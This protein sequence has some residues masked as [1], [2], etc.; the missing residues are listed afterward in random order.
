MIKILDTTLREGE[1]TP[2]VY[3]DI[4]IKIAIAKLLDKIGIDYIEVGHPIVSDSIYRA[5]RSISK[6]KCKDSIIAA[7]SRSV[8]DDID[9][10]L[11]C[12][13]DMIGIFYSIT[14]ERLENVFKV[15]IKEAT[16][17]ICKVITYAKSIKKDVLIRYTPEDTVRSDFNNVGFA[18]VEAIKNGADI[19]SI[20]DTTGFMIPGSN[21]SFYD[22]ISR[23][24]DHFLKQSVNPLI[25]IHCHNDRGL[26]LANAAD[27]IRAGIDIIDASV[28]G[29]GE[30]AGIVDLAQI[31][32]LLSLDLKKSKKY[33]TE[34]LPE[35]Y[36]LVSDYS[37]LKIPIN[38]PIIGENAFTH[39][40]GVH[41]HAAAIDPIH[42][43][44]ISP[45]HFNRKM[46]VSLDQM[47]GLSSVRYALEQLE[48][49]ESRVDVLKDLLSE[50]KLI[51]E[52]NRAVSLT[53]L[54]YL[55]DFII[56]EV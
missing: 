42:Y 26:A 35:L 22:Y 40:A 34:L 2:G 27:A 7:H 44:S 54:K 4:H 52:K 32:S 9:K 3:F 53:E 20:A 49:E 13:V 46:N 43:Q 15:D 24:R 17:K 38:M 30:R 39:C 12:D 28:L 36:N 48:I 18:A 37:G 1:Q 8:K 16:R 29:L 5:V 6:N 55:Y 23:L 31:M 45:E 47:S 21:N 51:G 33:K 11:E 41:T 10:A 50:V 56:S 25:A 19:I 14:T